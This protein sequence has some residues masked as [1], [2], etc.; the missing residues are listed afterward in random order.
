MVSREAQEDLYGIWVYIA[1]DSVHAANRV[2]Q[3][4]HET[5]AALSS[6]PRLGHLRK[7]LTTRPVLFFSIYSYLIVFEP[8]LKPLRILAVLHGYRN[9]KQVLKTR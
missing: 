6:M 1:R 3:E 9:V 2:E 5:F 7:D 8:E 4:M